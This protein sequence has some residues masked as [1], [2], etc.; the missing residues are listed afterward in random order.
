MRLKN[1]V[2]VVFETTLVVNEV[3]ARALDAMVGYGTKEFLRVF[4]EK[5]GKAY[6]EK[7]EKGLISLFGKIRS[8]MGSALCTVD[9]AR[10]ALTE[11]A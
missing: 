9:K 2:R 11:E 5:L 3:E 6:M 8:E 10:K 7:H 1:N 4:Y